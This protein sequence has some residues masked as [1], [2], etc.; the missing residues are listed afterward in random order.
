MIRCM[1]WIWIKGQGF[2]A[3]GLYGC[4]D[5]VFAVAGGGVMLKFW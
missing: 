1:M 4:K 5:N 2:G 3:L